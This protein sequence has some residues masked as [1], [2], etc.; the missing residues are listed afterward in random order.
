MNEE[1]RKKIRM[2]ELSWLVLNNLK[3]FDT[4]S[5]YIIIVEEKIKSIPDH[6]IHGHL[7][8]YSQALNFHEK[9][10]KFPDMAW[11]RS[12]FKDDKPMVDTNESFSIHIYEDLIEKL[13]FEICKASLQTLI[14]DQDESNTEEMQKAHK[15]IGQQLDKTRN[16]S[17]V[18]K[19]TLLN[20]Y[21]EYKKNY[22]GVKTHIPQLDEAMGFFNYQSLNV[23]GAPSGHGKSTFALTVAYNASILD[24]KCVDYVCYEM[25][26]DEMLFKI[27]SIESSIL[28]WDL[29]SSDMKTCALTEEQE[30][31]YDKCIHSLASKW[32]SSGGYL[33][34]IGVSDMSVDTFEGLCARLESIAEKR[35]R[36]AD[37]IV[38]DNV[39][40]F[41]IYKS[42]ERDNTFKV[43]TMI[44]T[45]DQYCKTYHNNAGTTI[46][47]L[48]QVNRDGIRVL[49]TTEEE[50]TDGRKSKKQ[51]EIDF[52]CLAKY[53]ALYERGTN[54]L[55]GYAP[56]KLRSLG[57]MN[58]HCV[59][60][61]NK[62][63]PKDCIKVPADYAH[64]R[65]GGQ[66]S[67]FVPD[68]VTAYSHVEQGNDIE[69]DFDLED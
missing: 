32:N 50:N 4:K 11:F 62:E 40:G 58:I 48:S 13:D 38:I 6:M 5:D 1:F 57:R 41:E 59:K 29:R 2:S 19:E 14:M 52:T 8:F 15:I 53:N 3:E 26:H 64:S 35:G 22:R 42:Q 63:T 65:I 44:R 20:S 23:F 31:L 27:A 39:D 9:H 36:P 17:I 33:N 55:V 16:Q 25:P 67:G 61:R 46:L 34:L 54:V 21:K 10:K 24:G 51:V 28:G 37:L 45:L 56:T 12:R 66:D 68:E 47:L 49:N 69:D 7:D 30:E 18:T 43:N 60:L